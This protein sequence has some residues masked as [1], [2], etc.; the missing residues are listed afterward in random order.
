MCKLKKADTTRVDK[1]CGGVN[2][3]QTNGQGCTYFLLLSDL[4][5]GTL[6]KLGYSITQASLEIF[7]FLFFFCWFGSKS[8]LCTIKSQFGRLCN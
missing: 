6:G 5:N 4:I 1:N 7:F 8:T 3:V 2:V